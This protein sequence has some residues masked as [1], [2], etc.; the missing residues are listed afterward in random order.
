L[1]KCGEGEDACGRVVVVGVVV[2]IVVVVVVIIV[3]VVV[4]VNDDD[5]GL[6][7]LIGDVHACAENAFVG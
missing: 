4:V 2:I 3:V 1:G 5:I 6:I 7:I